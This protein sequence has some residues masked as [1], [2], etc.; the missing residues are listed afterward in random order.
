MYRTTLKIVSIVTLI[1]AAGCALPRQGYLYS[2]TQPGR[3]T[4]TFAN[5]KADHGKLLASL[6]NGE[7]CQGKFSTI[8]G[9]RVSWDFEQAGVVQ[10]E[11]TQDGMAVFECQQ[12]HLLRCTFTREMAGAGMGTCRDNHGDKLT[13]YF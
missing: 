6:A 12:G 4:L 9:P 8:P 3:G 7:R 5:S 10:S 13:M 11:D 2:P 1:S